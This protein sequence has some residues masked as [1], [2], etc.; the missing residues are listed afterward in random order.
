MLPLKRYVFPYS[1]SFRTN[2]GLARPILYIY[3]YIYHELKI[4]FFIT[5][6]IWFDYSHSWCFVLIRHITLDFYHE[7]AINVI[8]QDYDYVLIFR[9]DLIWCDSLPPINLFIALWNEIESVKVTIISRPNS[10]TSKRKERW[11]MT[12]WDT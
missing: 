7:F 5:N 11:Q 4:L 1:S 8:I 10:T 2:L 9:F 3:I 12:K 6:L